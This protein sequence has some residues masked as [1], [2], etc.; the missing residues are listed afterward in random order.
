MDSNI[1]NDVENHFTIKKNHLITI[2]F[3]KS[4][5]KIFFND[6]KTFLHSF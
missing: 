2:T 4:Q 1:Q 6:H 5:F 3:F